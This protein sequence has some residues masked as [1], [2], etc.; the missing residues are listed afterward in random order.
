MHYVH[1]SI[2]VG[3]IKHVS[4][5]AMP[6]FEP[7]VGAALASCCAWFALKII[8]LHL[9]TFRSRIMS[10]TFGLGQQPENI[11]W[12]RE[13]KSCAL[14]AL[15]CITVGVGPDFGGQAFVAAGNAI[16]LNCV[17]NEPFFLLLAFSA[18]AYNRYI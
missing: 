15:R 2:S 13:D 17:L 10:E 5:A 12:S 7:Q 8:L 1:L 18:R 16:A 9:L 6:E 11:C 4:P 14:G 3:W